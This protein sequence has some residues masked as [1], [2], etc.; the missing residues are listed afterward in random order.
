MSAFVPSTKWINKMK[1][2]FVALDVDKNGVL[3]DADMVLLAKQLAG[4]NN[5]GPE[6]EKA[7]YETVKAVWSDGIGNGANEEQFIEGMERFVA[8]PDARERLKRYADMGFDAMDINKDGVV[9]YDEH[10]KFLKATANMSD[11]LI[12]QMFTETDLN[13]DGVLSRDESEA[14]VLD[15]VLST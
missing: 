14:Q 1:A 10:A 4:Y 6:V 3:T 8:R 9:T 13:K 15:F 7:Y 5:Q 12:D 11:E 2:R